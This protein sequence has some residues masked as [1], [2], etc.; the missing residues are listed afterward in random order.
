MIKQIAKLAITLVA[1]MVIPITGVI[2]LGA[3]NLTG[4]LS[5]L[6]TGLFVYFSL[7]VWYSL[8]T[9]RPAGICD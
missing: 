7:A 5:I 8:L 2:Y 1:S 3:T 4:K 9:H 6:G